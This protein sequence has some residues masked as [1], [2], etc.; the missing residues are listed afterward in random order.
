[1]RMEGLTLKR[2][3]LFVSGGVTEDT[4]V[5]GAWEEGGC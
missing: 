3:V 2:D 4:E 1:M 5:E